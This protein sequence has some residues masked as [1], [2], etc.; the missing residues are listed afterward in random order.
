[1]SKDPEALV[2]TLQG[3]IRSLTEALQ[4]KE[5]ALQEA[6]E[7]SLRSLADLA[8]YRKRM[9]EDQKAFRNFA[10]VLITLLFIIMGLMIMFRVKIDPRTVVSFQ[11]ALPKIIMALILVTFSYAIVGLL[12]D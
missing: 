1:M 8:N 3:E 9:E 10:Y 5:H 12:I 11:S 6:T 2:K 7:R 4:E